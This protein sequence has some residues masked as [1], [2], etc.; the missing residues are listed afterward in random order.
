MISREGFHLALINREACLTQHKLQIRGFSLCS[1]CYVCNIEQETAEHLFLQCT[2]ARQCW[3]LFL[4]VMG[5]SLVIPQ[6]IGSF[7]EIWQ[8]QKVK[9]NLKIWRTIPICVLR[10]GWMERNKAC[11]EGK[12]LQIARI[13]N[14]C[15][16]NLF[17][18]C[19]CN[20]LDRMDQYLGFLFFRRNM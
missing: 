2:L 13:K 15:I 4:T 11:F 16:K 8:A 6:K 1:R 12:R 18:R 5:V 9:K 17:L 7:S 14:K 3:E 10:T 19:S 20:T